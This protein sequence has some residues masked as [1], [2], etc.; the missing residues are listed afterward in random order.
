[1]PSDCRKSRRFMI[2]CMHRSLCDFSADEQ[3]TPD[4]VLM[5]QRLVLTCKPEQPAPEMSFDRY[6]VVLGY[7]A[8]SPAPPERLCASTVLG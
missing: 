8:A 1:M 3:C 5:E 7:V 2:P 6:F 4:P